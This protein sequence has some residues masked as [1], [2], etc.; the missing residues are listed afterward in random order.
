MSRATAL[1]CAGLN[2]AL[3]LLAPLAL[4]LEPPP[5]A[6]AI[7]VSQDG[8]GA[9]TEIQR[10]IELDPS[11][12]EPHL[13]LGIVW[14]NQQRYEAAQ[15]EFETALGLNPNNYL[16]HGHLG[17]LFMNQGRLDAA[18]GQLRAALRLNPNDAVAQENLKRV[19]DA[20][21]RK[22]NTR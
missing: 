4:A 21:A 7:V 12:D 19:M 2:T 22:S 14:L 8:S 6:P 20:S 17:L 10:A 5:A 15:S 1:V 9:Y 16:A 13:H 18:E 3:L 11:D